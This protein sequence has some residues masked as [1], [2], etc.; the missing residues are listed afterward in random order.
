MASIITIWVECIEGRIP[1]MVCCL[2]LS[3]STSAVGWLHRANFEPLVQ[4]VHEECSRYIT[5]LM[6]EYKSI[7]YSQHQK[8]TYNTIADL[9]SRW[10]FLTDTELLIFIRSSFPSQIPTS[11]H[12]SPLPAEISSWITSLLLKMQTITAS[13]KHPTTTNQEHDNDGLLGYKQW[14]G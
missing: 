2:T 11:F 14:A 7:L 3:D 9:L 6:M 12:I 1:P 5:R 8:R 13:K 10:H 4:P